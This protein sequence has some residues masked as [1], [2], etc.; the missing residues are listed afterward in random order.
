[1]WAGVITHISSTLDK[2]FGE[3]SI[4]LFRMRY[5]KS[6]HLDPYLDEEAKKIKSKNRWKLYIK[7]LVLF[8]IIFALSGLLIGLWIAY[9]T[10]SSVD[11]VEAFA[12]EVVAIS[13]SVVFVTACI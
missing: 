8:L 7:N 10:T 1:M 12:T 3:W 6:T 4:K 5:Y 11:E 2:V 9:G 13:A